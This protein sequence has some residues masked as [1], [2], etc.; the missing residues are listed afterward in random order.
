MR[1][2]GKVAMVTG[3]GSGIGRAI[4]LA[5]AREGADI[6]IPDIQIEQTKIPFG[7]VATDIYNGKRVVFMSGSMR[8][9]ADGFESR[10]QASF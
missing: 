1:L 6:L 4:V 9:A 3:G 2:T 7:C 5:L 10:D 8:T